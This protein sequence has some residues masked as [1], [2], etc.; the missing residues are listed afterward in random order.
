MRAVLVE[1]VAGQHLVEQNQPPQVV[2]RR[3]GEEPWKPDQGVGR[4]S[5]VHE[6]LHLRP[7]VKRGVAVLVE[8]SI[9]HDPPLAARVEELLRI[10]LP[11]VAEQD[12]A[13]AA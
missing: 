6:L 1:P 5:L 10:H 13:C 12:L 2:Q 7:I 8:W 9:D 3:F 11:D 4:F